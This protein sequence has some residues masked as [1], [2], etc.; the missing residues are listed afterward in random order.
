MKDK[1]EALKVIS[2]RLK[3]MPWAICS[4][5]AVE[6]F[7]NGKRKGRDIDVIVSGDKMDEVGKR[8]NVKPVMETREKE[9]IKIIN[10][11]HIETK[12]AG[13]PVEFIGQIEKFIIH[14]EECQPASPENSRKL[15]EKVQKTKY[16]GVEVFVLPIE[17][18]LAQKL[19]WNRKGDW[20]DE[21]DIKLLKNHKISYKLLV[22]AFERWSVSKGKQKELLKRYKVLKGG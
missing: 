7:T 18:T 22:E 6:I 8:F 20:Q 1:T 10:D 9:G 12:V 14:G 5:T 21:E 2:E 13:V 3:D 4:G 19:I 15:F 11:Y 17:E 16:L